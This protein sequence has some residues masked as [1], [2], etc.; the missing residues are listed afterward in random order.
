MIFALVV[1]TFHSTQAGPGDWTRF[2]V[3][4]LFIT[5]WTREDLICNRHH[6]YALNI[7][8]Y[9]LGTFSDGLKSEM[10]AVLV[11]D[12]IDIRVITLAAAL[13]WLVIC[14]SCDAF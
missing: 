2:G 3:G 8:I 11:N 10:S 12:T 14:L 6:W 1:C 7:V 5:K 9:K 13:L 4:S